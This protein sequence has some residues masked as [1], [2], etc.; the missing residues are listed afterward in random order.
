MPLVVACVAA[1]AAALLALAWEGP[2]G[3]AFWFWLAACMAGEALW[4]RLPHGGATL[5]MGSCMNVAALLVLPPHE[6]MLATALATLLVEGTLMR[7]P[8]IRAVYNASHTVLAVGAAA[9]VARNW[10]AVGDAI[11]LPAMIAAAFVYYVLNR[12]AVSAAVAMHERASLAEAFLRNFG[13]RHEMV[14]SGA[15][16][17]LGILLGLHYGS[18]GIAGT[19][20]VVLPL[21]VAFDGYRRFS[22]RPREGTVPERASPR[23]AA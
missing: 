15:V 18:T 19:L 21:F 17:S 16:F 6:A 9:L 7:K 3:P 20:L 4:L 10:P 12:L 14:S 13:H 11:A 1:A 8:A 5:S 23:K 22:E 2:P